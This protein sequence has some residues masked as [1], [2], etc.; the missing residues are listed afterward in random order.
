MVM[1]KLLYIAPHLSTG[2]LPQ[3]LYKKIELLQG[4]FDIY[5]VE[6]DDHTG[7]R[8]VVQRNKIANLLS[9]DHF[10]TLNEDK[11]E[12][13]NIIDQI[14]PDIIHLEEIPEFFMDYNLAEKIY[15]TDRSYSIIETSHDSSYDTTQKKF[16]PDKFMFVSDWQIQQY[17]DINIPKVLVEYPI[18]Y[19]E[20]PNREEALKALGLDPNKKHILH[21]GLFTPRKNQAEFFEYARALP[22]YQFHCVGNQADNFKYY[23]EP[24]MQNKP[25]NLTWWN[26]RSD[27]D[28]FYSAMDLFLF[29]S[30]GNNNDKETMPLVIREAISW[31][32]P[33]LIYNLPVYLNYFDKFNNIQYLEFNNI[34]ENCNKITE[35]LSKDNNFVNIDEEVFV[36]SVYPQ[37]Q[38]IIE[39]TKECIEGI[40]K[41]NRKIILT[42]HYPI[43]TELQSLVDYCVYDS[44]NILTKMDFYKI[45]YCYEEN[46]EYNINID[47]ENNNNSYHGPA[48]YT[49][50]YNGAVLAQKLGF[51]KTYFINF[52]YIPNNPEYINYISK[53]LNTKKIY[54]GIKIYTEGNTVSTF[55][56]G[57]QTDFFLSLYPKISTAQEYDLL[58]EKWQSNSVGYEDIFYCSLKN[59]LNQIHLEPE[60]QWNQLI[61]TNFKH[62]GYSRIEYF[63]V[64]PVQNQDNCFAI[65]T[66]NSSNT[67]KKKLV[68]ELIDN[69]ENKVNE[70][71]Y[72]NGQLIWYYIYNYN[73]DNNISISQ[74]MY[75]ID[76]KLLKTHTITIDK[77]YIINQLPK[78]GYFKF[79]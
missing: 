55:F 46:F 56:F 44:N 13:L 40:R 5:L 70:T 28:S 58:K 59:H 4:E 32:L 51:K 3:Y 21:V 25:D 9:P 45:G 52:D 17:K 75:D 29:T 2:G 62:L 30:K 15:S 69:N 24:L 23:W 57:A 18:E 26:E 42:S 10:F 66:H 1:K 22:E 39:A 67:D 50:Y 73:I 38:S 19:K 54:S 74:K 6:W 60:E 31:Q 37:Q 16:F 34:K 79:K 68:I 14:K 12:L 64:L 77:N 27:V 41:T 43:P 7:G 72:L 49:N 11:K 63:S 47:E 78:N 48:V 36:L 35:I 20:R 76:D 53:V 71:L 65:V 33:I 61:Q 8:L